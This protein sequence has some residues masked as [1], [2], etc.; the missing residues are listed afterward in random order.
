VG[1]SYYPQ[2]TIPVCHGIFRDKFPVFGNYDLIGADAKPGE[3]LV[4]TLPFTGHGP[5]AAIREDDIHG[6]R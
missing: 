4:D 5:A 2:L 3:D 6:D 1:D